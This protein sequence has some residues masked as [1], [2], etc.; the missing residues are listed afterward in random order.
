M[1]NRVSRRYMKLLFVE[2][3]EHIEFG[4]NK[5]NCKWKKENCKWSEIFSEF[6]QQ[7]FSNSEITFQIHQKC[8]KDDNSSRATLF[9]GKDCRNCSSF[10][11]WNSS[12][13]FRN[14]SNQVSN[15]VKVGAFLMMAVVKFCTVVSRFKTYV[16]KAQIRF[17]SD[18]KFFLLL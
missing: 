16:L 1:K 9:C 12:P 13:Q 6:C 11:A 15:Q 10:V 2:D 17:L 14:W 4:L 5:A 18:W 7:M 3:W 8:G